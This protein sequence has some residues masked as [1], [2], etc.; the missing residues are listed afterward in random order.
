VTIDSAR[1]LRVP[2]TANKKYNTTRPVQLHTCADLDFSLD[3]IKRA[4]TPYKV[5]LPSVVSPASVLENV[6]L[7]PQRPPVNDNELG[8]GVELNLDEIRS[9][10]AA[11]PPSAIA[12]EGEWVRFA[13]ALAYAAFMQPA[14]AEELWLILDTT[15]RLAPNYDAAE[16]RARWERYV[17]EAG[18]R[19]RPITIATL[20]AM[21]RSAGWRLAVTSNGNRQGTRAQ[22]AQAG[23]TSHMRSPGLCIVRFVCP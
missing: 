6:A 3:R 9:A 18:C 12:T 23:T 4:L 14:Q 22:S 21:A 20:Y 2:G 11:I 16:N 1:L 17:R 15:S 8:A 19:E 13:R 5:A 10:V 7:F